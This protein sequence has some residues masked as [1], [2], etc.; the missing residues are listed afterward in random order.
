MKFPVHLFL[1]YLSVISL[2][3]CD[4]G[5]SDIDIP[6]PTIDTS[7]TFTGIF[8]NTGDYNA[9]SVVE[10]H[11]GG[12]AIAGARNAGGWDAFFILTDDSGDMLP[13]FP[14]YFGDTSQDYGIKVITTQDGGYA[15]IG[16]TDSDNMRDEIFFI[17]TDADG[18]ILPGFPK[19]FG[20]EGIDA[21]RAIVQEPNGDFMI[22]GYSSLGGTEGQDI[23]LIKTDVE[24]NLSE[25]FPKIFGVTDE[26]DFPSNMIRTSDGGYAI[27]SRSDG[28]T[29]V[30]KM[31]SE[32]NIINGFPRIFEGSSSRGETSIT[33]T[34]DGDLMVLTYERFNGEPGF[35]LIKMDRNGEYRAGYPKKISFY[36]GYRP[37]PHT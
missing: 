28:K 19:T 12:L 22:M 34:L 20:R 24:G 31:D 23:I 36:P 33:E 15:I 7:N 25:G 26:E 18:E 3:S 11:N 29:Y 27:I 5:G 9:F 6:T 21:G 17:K 35:Y 10:A 8:T 16:S 14:K 32:G 13:G 1:L 2:L 37:F 30:M 4:D